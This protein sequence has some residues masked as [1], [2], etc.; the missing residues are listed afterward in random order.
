[1]TILLTNI[2]TCVHITPFG[3]CYFSGVHNNNDIVM[4]K[5]RICACVGAWHGDSYLPV[6]ETLSFGLVNDN[7]KMA[8]SSWILFIAQLFASL[9]VLEGTTTS[10]FSTRTEATTFNIMAPL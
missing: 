3:A 4:G 1:M 10:K 2:R 6:R 5:R 8:H 7:L 9:S